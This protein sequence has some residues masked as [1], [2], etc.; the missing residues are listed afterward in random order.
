MKPPRFEYRDP[1]TI[2]E[3]LD[4]LDETR[5]DA[6][7]LAGGQSLVPLLNMRL[8]RPEVLVDLGRVAGLDGIHVDDGAVVVGS[9]VRLSTLEREESVAAALPILQRVVRFVAHP[10]I[11][12]RTTIGG[13]LCH[14]DPAAELPALAVALGARLHLRSRSGDRVVDAEDFFQSVFMTA[15]RPDE[16][17]AAVE[18]PRRTG[19]EFRYDEISRRHGD[20]P[21]VG[22]CLGVERRGGVVIAA[23]AAAAGVADRPLRL[24]EL[25]A[26]LVG[27]R[28][29]EASEGAAQAASLEAEP[30]PDLHG[31]TEFRRGLLRTLVRRLASEFTEVAA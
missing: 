12:N 27:H 26:A 30:R 1:R 17:L 11:R 3:V 19:L 29:D 13:S 23:R 2:E 18:F 7:L 20:F 6:T 10:Q 14:A 9:T 16:L 21:F 4:I 8:A 28:L 22:L 31:S 24:S 5:D 25:E 15:K